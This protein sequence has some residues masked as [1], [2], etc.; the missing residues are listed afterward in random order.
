MG[1][2]TKKVGIT[3]KYGPRYGAS[4]RKQ[5]RKIEVAQHSRFTCPFCGKDAVKR[6]SWGIWLCTKC[7]HTMA[8]GA[9]TQR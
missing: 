1:R 9:S 4:L 6:D 7:K 2:R 8:G 3:G 5:I